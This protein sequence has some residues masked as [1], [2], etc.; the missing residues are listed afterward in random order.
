MVYRS[1][2]TAPAELRRRLRWV[3]LAAVLAV[4]LAFV[5]GALWL[6]HDDGLPRFAHIWLIVMENRDYGQVIGSPDSP[7]TNQLATT[8]G[9]ATEYY[10][11]THGSQPNY[12]GLFSGA[13]YGVTGGS[14]PNL[15]EPNLADQIEAAHLT[16]KVFAENFPGDCYNGVTASGG[17]D[18]PGTYVRRHVPAIAFRD[19]RKSPAR[20]AN[21]MDF[22][23]LDPAVANFE[24]IVPNLTD[25]G[26]DGSSQEA[27]AFL[28]RFVPGITG[29]SAWKDG[30]VLFIVWDEGKETGDNHVVAL[31]ISPL[32]SRGFRSIVRHDH[33]SLLRTIEDAWGLPCL[34][35]ACQ[36]NT[37]AEFFRDRY[38][39][40]MLSP[41]AT[42]L[43]P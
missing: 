20:C 36:A 37:V 25:D 15:V 6:T 32:V 13:Q 39:A 34:I 27:D 9:L 8:Y 18:G 2:L 38:E 21:I 33:Y 19:I 10:A 12:I 28:R 41:S 17:A 26:H 31:V 11:I 16:W 35:N 43:S 29:S 30:G 5:A 24:L 3:A 14:T 7:Y 1:P 22:L 4:G 23:H 42:A 40:S